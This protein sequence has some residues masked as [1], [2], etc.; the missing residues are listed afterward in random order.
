MTDQE[1]LNILRFV[2][3]QQCMDNYPGIYMTEIFSF[4]DDGN[5]SRIRGA[6]GDKRGTFHEWLFYLLVGYGLKSQVSFGTGKGGLK[7]W[8]AKCYTVDFLNEEDKSIFEIDGNSH[9]KKRAKYKDKIR[10]MFFKSKG[11][12]TYRLT[13]KEI[14]KYFL[15]ERG[16]LFEQ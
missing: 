11:Y 8:G 7:R 4:F 13:N 14:E 3:E 12:R 10:D 6:K 16:Y 5:H 9:N 1:K 15:E 2:Y